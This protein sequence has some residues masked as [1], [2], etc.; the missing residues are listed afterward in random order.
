MFLRFLLPMAV[1][2]LLGAALGYYGQCSSGT[3]PL[4]STWWRGALYGAS[5][6]L[7]LGATSSRSA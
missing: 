7:L 2:A 4:T 3:C 1:G 5:L 6:G